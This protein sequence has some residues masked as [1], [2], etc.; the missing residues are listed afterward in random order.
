MGA[1]TNSLGRD[2]GELTIVQKYRN[3]NNNNF[4]FLSLIEMDSD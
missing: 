4:Q 1:T 3:N 2:I